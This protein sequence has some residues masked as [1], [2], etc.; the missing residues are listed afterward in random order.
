MKVLESLISTP[1]L[2]SN[3][4]T[5]GVFVV[6]AWVESEGMLSDVIAVDISGMS[7]FQWYSNIGTKEPGQS[8]AQLKGMCFKK[9]RLNTLQ[10]SLA[11]HAWS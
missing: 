6:N 4:A 3:N 8:V 5:Y 7:L 9:R 11:M 2:I 1:R 10:R